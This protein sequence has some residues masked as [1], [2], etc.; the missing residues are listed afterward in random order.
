MLEI[1]LSIFDQ[2]YIREGD[3][4]K[5]EFE[6]DMP[7]ELKDVQLR[8]MKAATDSKLLRETEFADEVNEYWENLD[9]QLEEEKPQLP[10]CVFLQKEIKNL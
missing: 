8:L 2:R 9:K 7:E 4:Y 10:V 5:L 3:K 6:E 1:L